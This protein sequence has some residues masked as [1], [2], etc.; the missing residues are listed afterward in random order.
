MA[1]ES[2]EELL[3]I[4]TEADLDDLSSKTAERSPTAA[5]DYQGACVVR[6][7]DTSAVCPPQERSG[8]NKVLPPR[9]G[10][11]TGVLVIHFPRHRQQ[12]P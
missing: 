8:T 6:F 12:L 11:R 9:G 1:S 7:G 4:P 10:P 3:A 5:L 2:H